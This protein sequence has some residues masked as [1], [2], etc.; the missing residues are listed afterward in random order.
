MDEIRDVAPWSINIRWHLS[1]QC[2]GAV[3]LRMPAA[4]TLMETISGR[5]VDQKVG[6]E[7][8]ACHANRRSVDW[9]NDA[10]VAHSYRINT[11]VQNCRPWRSFGIYRPFDYQVDLRN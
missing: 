9:L 1:I 3:A 4:R 5:V 10:N 8:S 6:D 11:T 7:Q 2:G